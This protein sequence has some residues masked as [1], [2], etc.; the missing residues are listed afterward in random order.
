M[1]VRNS[2]WGSFPAGL[3]TGLVLAGAGA[4]RLAAQVL[5][6]HTVHAMV[7][8]LARV[9]SVSPLQDGGTAAGVHHFSGTVRVD[10]NGPWQ[11]Q[12]RL[13]APVSGTVSASTPTGS[14]ILSQTAWAVVGRGEGGFSMV[15]AVSYGVSRGSGNDLS[16][17]LEY[18]VVPDAEDGLG[19]S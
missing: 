11:L 9:V 19:G 13:A 16:A 4:R 15:T 8:S 6:Q 3:A 18:R 1:S 7:G 12:V 17:G 10:N 5:V 14:V 2:W